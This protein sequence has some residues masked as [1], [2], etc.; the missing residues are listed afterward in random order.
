MQFV[1]AV[2]YV[3]L[4]ALMF[5]GFFTGSR[6]IQITA[7]KFALLGIMVM[8]GVALFAEMRSST[9]DT[10]SDQHTTTATVTVT[11]PVPQP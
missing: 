3:V 4:L 7:I 1:L 8:L 11:E 10:P 6:D 2:F 9:N 5:I